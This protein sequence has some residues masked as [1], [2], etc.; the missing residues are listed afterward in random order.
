M[1]QMVMSGEPFSLGCSSNQTHLLTMSVCSFFFCLLLHGSLFLIQN[2]SCDSVGPEVHRG[3]ILPVEPAPWT[4]HAGHQLVQ[5]WWHF[6]G[7]AAA[8]TC[9]YLLVETML[10]LRC[11]NGKNSR[12]E[13]TTYKIN[14]TL[15]TSSFT[16]C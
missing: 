12:S 7:G 1:I 2:M 16:E 3:L 5:G 11:C 15:G 9:S 13:Q 6:A 10:L 14:F 4:R 8:L